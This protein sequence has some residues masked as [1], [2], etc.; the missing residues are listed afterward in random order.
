MQWN[1]AIAAIARAKC[2]VCARHPQALLLQR[3]EWMPKA[4]SPHNDSVTRMRGVGR[5][6]AHAATKGMIAIIEN[7]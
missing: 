5:A 7:K 1:Q 4:V 6:R 2:V 3:A